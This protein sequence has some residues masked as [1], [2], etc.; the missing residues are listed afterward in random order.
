MVNQDVAGELTISPMPP[1]VVRDDQDV[2]VTPMPPMPDATPMVDAFV[3]DRAPMP[4][5]APMPPSDVVGDRPMSP[6]IDAISPMP[7]MPPPFDG[8]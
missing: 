4:D 2:V 6:M 5:A 7:P 1:M 8:G 3:P